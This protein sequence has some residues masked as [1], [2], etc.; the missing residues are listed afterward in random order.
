MVHVPKTIDN[1]YRGIDFTFG[2]FTAVE[3]L[4]SEIRNLLAD[5]EATRMLLPRRDAWAAAPAGWPTG[6]R[7]PAR[8]AWS[9][10]VEDI[11]EQLTA[12]RRPSPT[13]RPA[14]A[15]TRKIMNID[16]VVDVIVEAMLARE[17]EG[18]EFGV[19][20]LAEGL[21]E[22]LP[23]D[24]PGRHHV[25]RPRPHLA[26][27]DQPGAH[28]GQAGRGRVQEADRQ[29]ATADRSAA[30]LRGPLRPAAR[31][32]RHARQPARRRRLSALVETASTA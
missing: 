23:A 4:A 22:F 3:I 24:V 14:S 15:S 19:I 12:P 9:L 5:A 20:V 1:D 32:R 6:P 26:R 11:D 7:S 31:L 29:D 17:S 28:D 27:P 13:P 25:R 8:P 30:R 21:A 16:K 2:Y 10:S 18:K